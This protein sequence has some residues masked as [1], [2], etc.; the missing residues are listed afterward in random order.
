MKFIRA[1]GRNS[2]FA[3]HHKT[4]GVLSENRRVYKYT[5]SVWFFYGS[6]LSLK[7][8]FEGER[9]GWGTHSQRGAMQ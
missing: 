4:P 5:M 1:K 7:K 6:L 8:G 9:P 2:F 3:R